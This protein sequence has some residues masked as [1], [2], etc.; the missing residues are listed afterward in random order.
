MS[1][2]KL[3]SFGEFEGD[4]VF[5]FCPDTDYKFCVFSDLH[6]GYVN[7]NVFRCDQ[8]L[9]RLTK[10]LNES[11]DCDFLLSL[12]DFA[13]NLLNGVKPYEEL[14]ALLD[15]HGAR[16][17][18]GNNATRDKQMVY[19][20]VGNHEITYLEKEKLRDYIPYVEGAGNVY[21]FRHRDTLFAAYDALFT[22]DE[23]D[24]SPTHI[25]PCQHYTIPAKTIASLKK[26]IEENVD[27]CKSIV[28]FTHICLKSI[29]ES[30]KQ[31]WLET[32]LAYGL[33]VYIFEGHAHRENYQLF[34]GD[35]GNSAHVFTLPA[36]CDDDTYNR[37]EVFMRDGKLLRINAFE[38][39][40]NKENIL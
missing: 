16:L 18:N 39:P 29:K 40:F 22:A 7:Y 30:A 28:A 27:G 20:V 10:I 3:F 25:R 33:P 2:Q 23:E 1:V 36:V 35:N 37:Y 6:H 38:K 32:L 24:D 31:A 19:N 13:D 14:Y 9:S 5:D 26:L 17:F 21:A 12:G 8:G 15:S 4:G 11:K 34:L